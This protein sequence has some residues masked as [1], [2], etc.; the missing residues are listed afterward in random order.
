MKITYLGTTA[1]MWAPDERDCMAT[2]YWSRGKFYEARNGE[3]LHWLSRQSGGRLIDVGAHWGNHSVYALKSGIFDSALC[4]EPDSD[5][6]A[7]CL[8]N[9]KANVEA[10]KWDLIRC[11]L[12]S[13]A[14]TGHMVN[15][16]SDNSGGKRLQ[17]G[18]GAVE[19]MTLDSLKQRCDV[20]K[21]DV[22][23]HE[24]EV[25]RGGEGTIEANRPKIAIEVLDDNLGAVDQWMTGHS[26]SRT[27]KLANATPTY[28][29]EHVLR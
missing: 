7:A 8:H 28:I 22:E 6:S 15:V 9:L 23:G 27:L 17:L 29:Y 21:I 25:L 5:N 14:G 24:L 2:R 1:E 16:S 20:L 13:S 4:L 10:S 26:Y 18:S 19:V 3:L 11:A 12:S